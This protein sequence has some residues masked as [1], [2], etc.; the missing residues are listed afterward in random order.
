MRYVRRILL[1]AVLAAGLV[2]GLPSAAFAADAVAANEGSVLTFD[3][4]ESSRV[5]LSFYGKRPGMGMVLEKASMQFSLEETDYHGE[6]VEAYERL[7]RDAMAGAAAQSVA[8][9][10]GTPVLLGDVAELGAARE[11]VERATD[12]ASTGSVDP[13]LASTS[14]GIHH[15]AP[16]NRSVC[17]ACTPHGHKSTR[18]SPGQAALR[19]GK[20]HR[21]PETATACSSRRPRPRTD[22][23]RPRA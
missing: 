7:I 11:E 9:A 19:G 1:A 2:L 13:V 20:T 14:H 18:S 16:C 8:A 23:A 22:Y 5:S 12:W 6:T 10:R 15:G 4:D 3:L 21:D 17:G